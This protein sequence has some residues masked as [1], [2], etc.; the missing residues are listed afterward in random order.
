MYKTPVCPYC[1]K[2]KALLSKK[3]VG[4][5]V[6]EIDITSKDHLK[7]EMMTKS[8]GRKTVPQIFINGK[9]IGGCDDLYALD[10]AGELDKL[11]G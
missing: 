7:D 2:A 1:V 11:L 10:A 6:T 5:L 8:H 3:G 4:D 9:H